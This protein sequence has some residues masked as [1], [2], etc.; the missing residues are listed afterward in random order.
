MSGVF[1]RGVQRP[2]DHLGHLLIRNSARAAGAEFVREAFNPIP[3]KAP[4]PLS[5][6]M[7]MRPK[8][9]RHHLARQPFGAKQDHP[10]TV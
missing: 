7:F 2:L 10:A 9:R 6:R 5:N 1:R 3:D 8:L 4:A